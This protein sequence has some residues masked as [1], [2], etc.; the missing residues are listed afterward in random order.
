MPPSSLENEVSPAALVRPLV[1][2]VLAIFAM[3]LAFVFTAVNKIDHSVREFE[4]QQAAVLVQKLSH[5]PMA[6][7]ID[8]LRQSGFSD[9]YILTKNSALPGETTLRIF[10]PE[11]LR[12][13]SVAFTSHTPGLDT[14]LNGMPFRFPIIGA[15]ILV[16][17]LLV[18][19][20]KKQTG[21]IEARRLRAHRLAQTDALSGLPNRRPFRR[22]VT[23]VLSRSQR[24]NVSA[25]LYFIDLDRFKKVNDTYGHAV[26]DALICEVARRLEAYIS[27]TDFVARLSGDE[28]AILRPNAGT[29]ERAYVFGQSLIDTIAAPFNLQGFI[30]NIGASVGIAFADPNKITNVNDFCHTA[31][32]ALYAAKNRGRN[33]AELFTSSPKR[34]PQTDQEA[35]QEDGDT[36][37]AMAPAKPARALNI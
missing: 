18:A 1:L 27:K 14:F 35:W 6:E 24:S 11:G 19:R 17:L 22:Q 36:L 4:E 33:C 23:Q 2:A 3:N 5:E 34:G 15:S 9:A 10:S 31:D 29:S 26:G 13:G 30:V 16:I 8:A 28:F 12:R 20:L 37:D 21:R 25:A 7:I 32:N